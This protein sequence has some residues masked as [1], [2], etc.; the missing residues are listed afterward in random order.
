ME[1]EL[2]EILGHKVDLNTPGFL[3]RAFRDQVIKEAETQ[4]EHA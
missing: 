4:Y 1:R 3:S 2:S